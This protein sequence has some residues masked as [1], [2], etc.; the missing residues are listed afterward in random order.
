MKKLLFI[1]YLFATF[2]VLAQGN[3]LQ[4][5][6]F[7]GNART[8]GVCFTL[9]DFGYYGTGNQ[10]AVAE[11][12]D[13]WRYNATNDSWLQMANV[14]MGM[15]AGSAASTST[16]GFIGIGWWSSNAH[17]EFFKYN[18]TLNNWTTVS[19]YIGNLTNDGVAI[20]LNNI[21][22]AGLGGQPYNNNCWDDW[23]AFN[24]LT[25]T[26]TSLTNF[27]GIDRRNPVAFVLNNEIYVGGGQP[28]GGALGNDF[29]K[30]DVSL[31]SWAPIANCPSTSIGSTRNSSFLINGKAYLAL[32]DALWQY[33]PI[34]DSWTSFSMPFSEGVD[35]AFSLNGKGYIIKYGS[36]EVWEWSS[37]LGTNEMNFL[38]LSIYPNPTQDFLNIDGIQ[39]Q[40]VNLQI[41]NLNGATIL[42]GK[43]SDSK[44]DISTLPTGVYILELEISNEIF[45]SRINKQ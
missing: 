35:A 4:K 20:S 42:K 33:D 3:W 16:S 45:R 27:P 6:D 14:P 8:R 28:E 23:K 5:N 26:W 1:T 2:S 19:N 17:P 43:L 36:K 7:S 15:Q 44:V 11:T 37:T 41:I 38:N 40:D 24:E 39:G 22:Y 13:F 34:N 25:S 32:T 18:P 31:D 12:N 10:G 30:Y 21:V 9:N 29:Y